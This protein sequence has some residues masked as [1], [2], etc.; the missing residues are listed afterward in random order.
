[1]ALDEAQF[2]AP[3]VAGFCH[4]L[5]DAGLKVIAAGLNLTFLRQPWPEMVGLMCSAERVTCLDAVCW[6]CHKSAAFTRRKDDDTGAALEDIG[7]A[8]KYFASCRAC[9]RLPVTKDALVRLESVAVS[10][11]RLQAS[12]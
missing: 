8:D 9:W 5:A 7:G 4:A 11:Q 1:V 6:N 3:D 2:M 10:L 12:K